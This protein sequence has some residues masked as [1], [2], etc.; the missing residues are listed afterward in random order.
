MMAALGLAPKSYPFREG[1]NTLYDTAL[2]ESSII[3]CYK[4]LA[5][6]SGF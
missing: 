3:K 1:R 4:Y 2:D 5:S 6:F